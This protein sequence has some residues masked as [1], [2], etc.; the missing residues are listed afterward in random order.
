MNSKSNA[1]SATPQYRT[2]AQRI[3]E[4]ELAAAKIKLVGLTVLAVICS[5]VLVVSPP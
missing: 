3:T 5:V 2:Q 4:Y 1:V